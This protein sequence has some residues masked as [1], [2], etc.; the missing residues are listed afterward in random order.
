[1]HLIELGLIPSNCVIPAMK[2]SPQ[3]LRYRLNTDREG[4]RGLRRWGFFN[5]RQP[6]VCASTQTPL[7]HSFKWD[8]TTVVAAA[9]IMYAFTVLLCD[10]HR[11][12]G[13]VGHTFMHNNSFRLY[14]HRQLGRLSLYI[15]PPW[16]KCATLQL[17]F[18]FQ[19]NCRQETRPPPL[20][21]AELLP[22]RT[23]TNSP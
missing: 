18:I 10:R 13:N 23:F 5:Q 4:H 22:L 3:T 7:F 15:R 21:E 12:C 9:W 17:Q 16:Q 8:S 2:S 11:P 19:A 6:P 20:T 14:S 1:M